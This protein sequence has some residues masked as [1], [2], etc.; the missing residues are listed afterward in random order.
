[1]G[2]LSQVGDNVYCKLSGLPMTLHDMD[3]Q[4]M[5]PWIEH[6]LELFGPS[7]CLIGSNFPVDRLFGRFDTLMSVYEELT[8]PLGPVAQQ[9]VFADNAARVYRIAS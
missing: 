1:M 9:A 3:T 8:R 5:R 6:C 7:R 4:R 2:A